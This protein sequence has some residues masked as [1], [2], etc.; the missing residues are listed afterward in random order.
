MKAKII[1]TEAEY[2]QALAYIETLMDASPG[3]PEEEEL[4]LFAVLVD[5]YERQHFPID[6][7][8]PVEAILFRMEQQGL[9]RKDLLPYIGSQSKVSEVLN[10]KRPLS[11]AMI[12]ALHSGL[13]IP[14]EVLLQEPGASLEAPQYRLQDY[15]FTEMYQ[16]GYFRGFNGTL[17]EAKAQA[18]ELLAAL[19]RPFQRNAPRPV[20]C[21][22]SEGEMDHQALAAWQARALALADEQELP[23]FDPAELTQERLVEVIRLSKFNSG[24]AL[25]AELLQKYG[26]VLVILPHLPRT[27]LDGACFL[28]PSGRPIIGLTLRHDR[29]DHFWFTMAHE[30]A[31]VLLHLKDENLVFFDETEHGAQHSCNPQE[32]EANALATELLISG[33]TWQREKASLTSKARINA[34]ADRLGIHPAIIAGRLRWESGDYA[35]YGQLLGHQSVRKLFSAEPAY[36]I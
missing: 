15:P 20:Y 8:D 12:R 29:L 21:R 35:T 25:A 6:L 13:G 5:T 4:E 36:A 27:Y 24:P 18:E 26:I 1:K 34:L 30:L 28:S 10:K 17:A 11:L 31:H 16:R 22:N 2:E 23:P 19:F 14:A 33:E 9:T 32:V 7:P 3:T